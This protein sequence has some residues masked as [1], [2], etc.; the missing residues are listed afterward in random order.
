MSTRCQNGTRRCPP[1]TGKC[2]SSKN[3]TAKARSPPP[4]NHPVSFIEFCKIA[5][6]LYGVKYS[7]CKSNGTIRMVYYA[8]KDKSAIVYPK[9][10]HMFGTPADEYITRRPFNKQAKKSKTGITANIIVR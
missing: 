3:K 6:E 10:L 1:K 7:F 9:K 5:A 2:F 8:A 4:T